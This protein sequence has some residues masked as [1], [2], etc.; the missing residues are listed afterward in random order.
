MSFHCLGDWE[1]PDG[2]RYIALMD[3]QA[4]SQGGSQIEV[5]T[6]PRY[7][8]AVSEYKEFSHH[9]PPPFTP[10]PWTHH[11]TMKMFV[12]HIGKLVIWR[13]FCSFFA[14]LYRG[15]E[16]GRNQF[17][18]VFRFHVHEPPPLSQRWLWDTDFKASANGAL[19]RPLAICRNYGQFWRFL[20]ITRMES[21]QMGTYS[22]SRW[23]R[24]LEGSI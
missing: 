22:C 2:H 1:G 8:C 12:D 7:R 16:H 18:S 6:R 3:T 24:G 20:W 19:A 11:P 17:S 23:N 10:T 13:M 9:L 4:T 14:A 21:G 15:C 5:E